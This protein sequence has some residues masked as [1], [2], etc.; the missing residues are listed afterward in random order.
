M[1]VCE[2]SADNTLHFRKTKDDAQTL[3]GY[4][5]S[6]NL[7]LSVPN[8]RT[9]DFKHPWCM[10]CIKRSKILSPDVATKVGK[11]NESK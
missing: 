1:K 10:L 7:T 9:I 8:A 5:P 6:N 2:S 3:C 4:L 11:S